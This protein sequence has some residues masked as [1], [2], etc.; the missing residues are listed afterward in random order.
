MNSVLQL[1]IDDSVCKVESDPIGIFQCLKAMLDS[2]K[3]IHVKH[4]DNWI[5]IKDPRVKSLNFSGA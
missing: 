1:K 4:G 5:D 2:G 3:I